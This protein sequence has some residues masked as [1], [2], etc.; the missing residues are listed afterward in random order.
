MSYLS[1]ANERRIEKISSLKQEYRE[2]AKRL[3]SLLA[4]KGY[5]F[6]KLHLFGS[7][8]DNRPLGPW[9]D[10]DLAIEGLRNDLFFKVYALL[11][12]EAKFP[13]DLK[14][15]EDLD[16]TFKERIE[17]KGEVIYEAR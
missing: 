5:E 9:S 14:P 15:F 4:K 12:K 17:R 8:L 10:I 3:A 16:R 1:E 11:L 13:V 7:S 6:K 2:E